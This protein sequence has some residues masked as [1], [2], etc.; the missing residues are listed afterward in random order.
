[1]AQASSIEWTEYSWNPVTGCT[2]ISSGCKNC[3]AERMAKRL[4]RMGIERYFNGFDV[5]MHA[6]L[7]YVPLKWRKP[8]LVFVNSMSDLFHK[9]VPE[10][11]IIKI[12]KTMNAC[13][14]HTFQVLTK[15]SV[16]L[17]EMSGKLNWTNNIWMGVTVEDRDNIYRIDDLRKCP[18]KLKFISCEPLLGPLDNLQ[19]D[20]ID[21]VIVGGES[22]PN[23]RPMKEEWAVAIR[24]LCDKE[25]IPFYFK[26]WG[27]WDKK[28]N[29][30]LLEGKIWDQMPQLAYKS[31]FIL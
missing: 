22:G 27:G 29:G 4:K 24:N 10:E 14:Q 5:R 3:Y 11:F 12:F 26:Q 19:L 21:W 8:R 30:R 25:R 7:L 13:P 16:R 31:Q 6:D 17:N 1:M 20:Q 9:D 2:K 28:A 23:A 15:R 18:A